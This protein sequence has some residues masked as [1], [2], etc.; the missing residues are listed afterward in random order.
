MVN[1]GRK[2]IVEEGMGQQK[3][4][5]DDGEFLDA[6]FIAQNMEPCPRNYEGRKKSYTIWRLSNLCWSVDD[7]LIQ[8]N[9]LQLWKKCQNFGGKVSV[10]AVRFLQKV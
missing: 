2:K 5:Y 4:D 6:F 10:E 3:S 1:S 9:V 7:F 8:T